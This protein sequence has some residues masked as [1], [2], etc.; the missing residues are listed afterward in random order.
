MSGLVK[1]KAFAAVA[2]GLAAAGIGGACSS[3]G[4]GLNFGCGPDDPCCATGTWYFN[5]KPNVSSSC[6]GCAPDIYVSF[7]F[8]PLVISPSVARDGGTAYLGDAGRAFDVGTCSIRH[9]DPTCN[10]PL[11][12]HFGSN[13]ASVDESVVCVDAIKNT[14]LA[15]C[16]TFTCTPQ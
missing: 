1:S 4:P 8:G 14:C 16:G 13:G 2:V 3:A 7:V 11:T 6:G 9:A 10:A 12:Y 15:V 5:C